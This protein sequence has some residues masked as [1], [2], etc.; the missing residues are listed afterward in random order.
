M[1]NKVRI[2]GDISPEL[3]LFGEIKSKAELIGEINGV[4]KSIYEND[5]NRLV[6]IP[7]IN[8]IALKGKLTSEDLG[9]TDVVYVDNFLEFPL[10]G[11]ESNLYVT[12]NDNKLY[13]WDDANLKYFIIG[14]D[15][16]DIK[17]INGGDASG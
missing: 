14:S 4:M 5:Y 8:D 13:R 16:N 17:I 2:T 15:Y 12:R 3:E 11:K 1:D 7:Y 6:N 10:I 9:I